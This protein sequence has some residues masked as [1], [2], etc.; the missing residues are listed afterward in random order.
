MHA[1]AVTYVVLQTCIVPSGTVEGT[2]HACL[3]CTLTAA[4]VRSLQRF[5]H[6][7]LNGTRAHTC[8]RA[9]KTCRTSA[10]EDK[11]GSEA[12]IL[13]AAHKRKGR[14]S[15]Q[16]FGIKQLHAPSH[17]LT[18]VAAFAI[19]QYHIG[20]HSNCSASNSNSSVLWDGNELKIEK[21]F[22]N[23]Q[24]RKAFS[25]VKAL[26]GKRPLF[27]ESCFSKKTSKQKSLYIVATP[28]LL[29]LKSPAAHTHKTW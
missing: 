10:R 2:L 6:I 7:V 24:L 27:V 4:I 12:D 18:S 19:R 8:T 11:A 1:N 17:V 29:L 23:C 9:Y 14:S 15:A 20:R 13:A 28:V 3:Y 26:L 22:L 21:G 25:I 5:K 16:A